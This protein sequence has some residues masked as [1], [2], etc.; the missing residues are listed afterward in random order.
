VTPAALISSRLR[1]QRLTQTALR[2]PADVV[3][4]LGAVQAQDFATAKWGLALRARGLTEAAIDRAF[5]DGTIL[6]THMMRPTWHFVTPADIRWLQRLTAP[7][8][9]ARNAPYY[10]KTGLDRGTLTR[11]R[12]VLER[13]LRDETHLTRAELAAALGR[14][15]IRASGV[16]LAYVMM[17]AE[18]ECVICSGPRRGKQ[19][20]YALFDER[21]PRARALTREQALAELTRRYV[22]SHG[23][24]TARDFAWWSGLGA[25][26]ARTG[27]EMVRPALV[28]TVWDGLT[29]WSAPSRAAA[30]PAAPT[31]HLLPNYDEYLIA[32][33][34]RGLAHPVPARTR[35][36]VQFD[37][38]GNFLIVDGRFAGTWRRDVRRDAVV[39]TVVPLKPMPRARRDALE[40]AVRAFGRFV[41]RPANLTLRR[42]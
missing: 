42:A 23:P 21:V 27:I 7:H 3:A 11:S 29:F 14:A 16:R 2:R 17:H 40:A 32:Y 20:T 13:A 30:P 33:Q 31:A 5:D 39:V 25:G 35:S 22:A 38:F 15:G 26:E 6:R 12:K 19:F 41:E 10:R 18:L 8:V 1:N 4:W 36:R 37:A 24:A 28:R 34:D 9:H